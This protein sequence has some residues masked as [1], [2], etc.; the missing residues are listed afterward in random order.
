LKKINI[1]IKR[2]CYFF[3]DK[4]IYCIKPFNP[5]NKAV[6]II[7]ILAGIFSILLIFVESIS[8]TFIEKGSDQHGFLLFTIIIEIISSFIF[9]LEF[10]FHL[11]TSYYELGHVVSNSK[12]IFQNYISNTFFFDLITILAL[13]FS[14]NYPSISG[15]QEIILKSL[16]FFKIKSFNKIKDHLEA[17]YFSE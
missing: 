8:M 17:R 4:F 6:T 12:Q 11:N 14:L 2:K 15:I 10:L 7:F 1:I 16:F 5:E 3:C 13:I 9:F